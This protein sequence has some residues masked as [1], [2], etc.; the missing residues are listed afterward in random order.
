MILVHF[1]PRLHKINGTSTTTQRNP[2]SYQINLGQQ[3]IPHLH[4]SCCFV[5]TTHSSS[6]LITVKRQYQPIAMDI[7][8]VHIMPAQLQ[9]R[10]PCP[11]CRQGL[12]LPTT[13][14]KHTAYCLGPAYWD[15]TYVG[16]ASRKR[17]HDKYYNPET[18]HQQSKRIG[19]DFA[20]C[21]ATGV[22]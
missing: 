7:D 3:H 5:P 21:E 15:S 18:L 9:Q 14:F 8:I 17:Q 20:Q 2:L 22:I 11:M 10:K 12:F 13:L 1:V 19:T 6:P 4:R 16:K